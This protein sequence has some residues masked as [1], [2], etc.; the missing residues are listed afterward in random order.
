MS[1]FVTFTPNPALDIATSVGRLEHA[2][3]LRCE[4]PQVHPGGGGIN[5]ARV[6]HRLGA[7]VQAIF[8]AGGPTGERLRKLLQAEA[9]PCLA[10]TIASDTR[11]SFTVHERASEQEFRFVLPGPTLTT[12]EW[13]GSLELLCSPLRDARW[14]IASGGLPPGVDADGHAQAIRLAKGLDVRTVVD[15]SGAALKAALDEGVWLVKPSLGELSAWVGQALANTSDQ[16][17]AARSLIE[18]GKAHMVALTLGEQGAML[19]THK[20]CLRANPV[21]VKVAGSVGAGDSFLAALVWALDETEDLHQALATA[22]AAGASAV[23]SSGTAL[24]NKQEIEQL[25][26]HVHIQ[27]A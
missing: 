8:P 16:L 21:P 24:C 4:A 12:R 14:L 25:R 22:M 26:Q 3:K 18:H 2:H 20:Q 17:K 15:T 10:H 1:R 6:L 7:D 23:M 13:Q 5:V 19:I 27:H 9:V 11:E